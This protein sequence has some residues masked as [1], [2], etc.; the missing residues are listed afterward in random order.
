M[1][2]SDEQVEFSREVV[3]QG[4]SKRVHTVITL[5]APQ[6]CSVKVTEYL[7]QEWFVD[8][9][10]VPSELQA[11]YSGSIDIEKP[12][13]VSSD[14]LYYFEFTG[15]SIDFTYPIHMRYNDVSFDTRYRSARLVGPAL[16]FS[17]LSREVLVPQAVQ[18]Y[19]PV[20]DLH[21]LPAVERI[22]TLV[23]VLATAVLLYMIHTTAKR[24]E[25]N[26]ASQSFTKPK[27]P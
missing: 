18:F 10:E 27:L 24:L 8:V 17:C 13:G 21:D 1:S 2:Y 15:S 20:G 22:T 12:T 26:K 6:A 5:K 19:M 4:F 11:V 7:P 23:V 9:D 14:S 3:G 16:S 25:A